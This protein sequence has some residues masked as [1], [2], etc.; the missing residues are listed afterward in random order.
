MP[1]FRYF[2]PTAIVPRYKQMVVEVRDPRPASSQSVV[3]SSTVTSPTSSSHGSTTP[4]L[5][6][7]Q[8]STAAVVAAATEETLP[9]YVPQ[10][11]GRIHPLITHLVDVFFIHLGSNFP[12]LRKEHFMCAIGD[13]RA[14]PLLVGAVCAVSSRFSTH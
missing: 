10:D 12:F 7:P 9:L 6:S 2:G 11:A 13:G 14:N 1:Y 5:T 8:P 3:S 4:N